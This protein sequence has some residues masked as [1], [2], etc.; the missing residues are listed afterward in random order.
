M[1]A[2]S[3]VI[4]ATSERQVNGAKTAT[5]TPPASAGRGRSAAVYSWASRTVLF[6]FQF[7]AIIGRRAIVLCPLLRQD[8]HTGQLLALDV[9]QGSSA[10]GRDVAH[11]V[12][13]PELLDGGDRVAA[14]DDARGTSL[15]GRGD[16][17]S[18]AFGAPGESLDLE[19]AH[20][21]VPED[22]LRAR[23]ALL[24]EPDGARTDVEAH[25]VGWDAVHTDHLALG[26]LLHPVGDDN[27]QG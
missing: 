9:L 1:T 4:R 25:F 5:S 2:E 19:D 13:E 7:A 16:G 24:E 15:A 10:T 17:A 14:P 8:R 12:L 3:A 27:V 21:A 23:D 22:G 6:I 26:T 11:P 18:D 20:R